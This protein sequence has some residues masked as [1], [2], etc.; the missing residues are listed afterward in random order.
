MKL[1]LH[2]KKIFC[3]L[4][5]KPSD[6]GPEFDEVL[7]EEALRHEAVDWLY[8]V[9]GAFTYIYMAMLAGFFFLNLTDEYPRVFAILGALQEPYLGGVGVYVILKEIRKRY[10]NHPSHYTGELFVVLW[11]LMLAA[12][13]LFAIFSTAYGFDNVF[14]I[15]FTNSLAVLVIFIGGFINRP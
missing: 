2:P 14:K 8:A 5:I 7:C 3:R 9:L 1:E 11:V 13:S 10:H 4:I 15:I 12:A 6:K